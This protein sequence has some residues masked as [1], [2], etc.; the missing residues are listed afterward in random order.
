MNAMD[1][2]KETLYAPRSTLIKG[3]AIP[4]ALL[5]V[6]C[7]FILRLIDGPPRWFEELPYSFEIGL[8][9]L[10]AACAVLAFLVYWEIEALLGLV[11]K[12]RVVLRLD[13]DGVECA[14]GRVSWQDVMHVLLVRYAVYTTEGRP[15]MGDARSNKT[16]VR[17]TLLPG[18]VLRPPALGDYCRDAS[19]SPEV[20][21]GPTDTRLEIRLGIGDA[22]GMSTIRRFYSG[23]IEPYS[24]TV[25]VQVSQ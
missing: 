23:M 15:L 7:Y 9:A 8:V 20:S 2:T 3:I 18:T 17:F 11:A 22:L 4:A 14:A 24:D 12:R 6:G 13:A 5:A 10:L 16:Y 19:Y 25:S 21:T 1:T